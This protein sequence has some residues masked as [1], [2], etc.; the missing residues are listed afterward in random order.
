MNFK[1][2]KFIEFMLFGSGPKSFAFIGTDERE[3][4]YYSLFKKYNLY[5]NIIEYSINRNKYKGFIKIVVLTLQF[6]RSIFNPIIIGIFKKDFELIRC[7]Q[8]YGSWSGLIL[9]KIS[10]KKLIIRVGYSWSQSIL[11]ESGKNSL[12][13]RISKIIERFILENLMV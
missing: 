3:N 13:Y 8:I 12:K 6:L 9:K 10:K 4:F 1:N 2:I 11:Y 5:P 7:K